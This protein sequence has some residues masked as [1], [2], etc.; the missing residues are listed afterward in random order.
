[1]RMLMKGNGGILS[2]VC[3]TIKKHESKSSTFIHSHAEWFHSV[4]IIFIK[5]DVWQLEFIKHLWVRL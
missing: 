3:I 1:M 5:M 4:S 2:A